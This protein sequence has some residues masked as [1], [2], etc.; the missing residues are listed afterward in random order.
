MAYKSFFE[1]LNLSTPEAIANLEELIDSGVTWKS[2]GS[3]I[4]YV[5]VESEFFRNLVA[6]C[7][8]ER[9]LHEDRD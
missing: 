7:L 6:K 8:L 1:D 4:E 5:D 2:N 9:D 3:I